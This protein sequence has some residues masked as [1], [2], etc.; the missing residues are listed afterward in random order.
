[1]PKLYF[2]HDDTTLLQHGVF[3]LKLRSNGFVD[4]KRINVPVVA[5][6]SEPPVVTANKEVVVR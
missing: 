6:S 4:S 2:V 1:M 3:A 5:E